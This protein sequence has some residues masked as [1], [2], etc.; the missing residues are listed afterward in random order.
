[1]NSVSRKIWTIG[2]GKGGVGKSFLTASMSVVLARMGKSVIAVDADLGSPNLHTF[3][4]IKSPGR[5]LLD[6]MEGRAKL[7]EVLLET[8]EP[9]LRM[10]SCRGCSLARTSD[11]R[12][13]AGMIRC[14]QELEADCV[15]VDLGSGT[16]FDVLDFFNL[17]DE[18][19]AVASPDPASIQNVY[20]FIKSAVFH[21]IQREFGTISTVDR[22]IQ[23]FL[24]SN[25]PRSRTMTDF[26]DVLCTTEPEI[27]EKASRLVDACHPLMI[28]NLAD[29]EEDQR[30]AEIVQTASKRFLNVNIRFCGIVFSDPAVRRATQLMTPLD[31]SA[32]NAI[33]APQIQNTVQRI[34]NGSKSD[35]KSTPVTPVPATPIMGLN[36]ELEILNKQLHI[37]TEDLGYTGR[38]ITTQVFCRGRVIL[39]TKSA[40]PSTISDT[41][42][43]G[44]IMDLMRRQHFNVIR[45]LESKKVRLL[46]HPA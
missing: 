18:G 22:A 30:V 21:R 6:H 2:G 25:D 5:S 7:E 37:Q 31:F 26:Y 42:G 46:H 32:P 36:D 15:L 39:S 45:E 27:A 33:A 29:S 41:N 23:E 38:C 40:Y 34:L 14:I 4:G 43:R 19:I 16:A 1:M 11:P 8:A 20:G 28:V 35:P 13:K 3:L 12:E 17:S 44:Q 24:S 10:L 9:G